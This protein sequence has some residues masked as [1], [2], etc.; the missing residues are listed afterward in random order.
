MK[1]KIWIFI[2]IVCNLL[3]IG[4]IDDKT[5]LNTTSIPLPDSVIITNS[6]T[7]GRT[8]LTEEESFSYTIT[9]GDKLSLSVRTVYHGPENLYYEWLI[10]DEVMSETNTFEGTFSEEKDGILLIYREG[11]ESAFSYPFYIRIA[12]PYSSGI[13]IFGNEGGKGVFD[14]IELGYTYVDTN[15][16]GE[17]LTRFDLNIHK[18]HENIYPLCNNGE[19]FPCTNVLTV[20]RMYEMNLP[21]GGSGGVYF[22][23]LDADY[24]KS[25]TVEQAS[26]KKT[27]MLS[28]E[29]VAIPDNLRPKDFITTAAISLLLD[30]SGKIYTRINYD[31]GLPLT[32]RFTS[33]PLT[34]NDPYDVPD[35]GSETIIASRIFPDGL[36]YE[37]SKKRFLQVTSDVE[38]TTISTFLEGTLPENFMSLNNFDAELIGVYDGGT[39]SPE[40]TKFLVY[41]KD[42]EYYVQKFRFTGST[43][44][45]TGAFKMPPEIKQLWDT[46]LTQIRIWK[47]NFLA[48]EEIYFA[49]GNAVYRMNESGTS[50]EKLFECND[51]DAKLTQFCLTSYSTGSLSTIADKYLNGHVYT[52]TFDNGDL[53]VLKV[54]EDPQQPNVKLQEYIIEKHY[55]GGIQCLK[56]FPQ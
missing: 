2:C 56:Y 26:I 11:G 12:A 10:G 38:T 47:A 48:S 27:T 32:G 16:N 24:T 39:Y 53:K 49:S 44:S 34:Y 17:L 1:R 19:E 28:D 29:F 3:A 7:G 23:I 50:V 35:K 20:E 37:S 33:E 18:L 25:L 13:M 51:M 43:Y 8:V 41:K 6:V 30:E 15:F 21:V 40:Y 22:Q 55:D 31:G 14:F 45:P 42:G 46:D 5:N 4:C 9:P 36:V 54:Y 52:L